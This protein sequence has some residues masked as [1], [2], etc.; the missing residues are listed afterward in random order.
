V[1]PGAGRRG[2]STPYY[3]PSIQVIVRVGGASALT[4]TLPMK[5]FDTLNLFCGG[6]FV[7]GGEYV[8]RC[9]A[10]APPARLGPD[11]NG[12][13]EYSINFDLMVARTPLN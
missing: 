13:Q 3:F 11:K 7:S 4:D 6:V 8:V 10:V 2:E 5:V 1:L 12:R 9:D